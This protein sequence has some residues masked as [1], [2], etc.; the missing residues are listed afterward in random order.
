ML[1]RSKYTQTTLILI[2]S[3]LVCGFLSIYFGKELNWDLAN[4][5]Y[6]N[7]FSFWQERW[8]IDY[9]PTS[10][11]HVHFTPTLD[12]LTYFLIN[13]FSPRITMF[14]MGAIHGMN[15]WLL[16]LIARLCLAEIGEIP[17]QRLIAISL[18]FLGMYGPTVLPG[19]GSFQHD[20]LVSIF[21]L[22]FVLL[23][24]MGLCRYK[25]EKKFAYGLFCMGSVLL[26][27]GAGCKLTAALFVGGALPAF[28]LL[29]LPLWQRIKILSVFS[30]GMGVGILCASGY[31][32][33]FLWQHYH[34]PFF[35]LLN[36]FFHSPDFPAY[37]WKDRRFLPHG[38]LQ[39]LFYP[40]Y[41]AWDGRTNDMPFRDFRYPI[42]YTLFIVYF[43]SAGWKY[44]RGAA[45][46]LAITSQWLF[47]F[48]IF[49]YI[50]WQSYFSIMRYIAAL[51]M[52]APLV[53]YLVLH[54]LLQ[55][56]PPRL[57]VAIGIFFLIM[58]TTIPS[59]MIR[60]EWYDTDYFNIK[61]PAFV[62]QT[63]E[64][65]V[66][67]AFSAYAVHTD[68]RPQTYL[69]PFFPAKWR[70]IGIPF[71]E[72]DY[73]LPSKLTSIIAHD[74]Y[75]Y[76]LS[77]PAYMPKMYTI[78]DAMG[79]VSHGQ[80]GLITSDRQRITNE[81]TWLCVVKKQHSIKK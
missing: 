80:C 57:L 38:W 21:I 52:L 35:P 64:A 56:R 14:I 23:Q 37:N 20:N 5:H 19:I 75:L 43:I 6:Y 62:T 9:W 50:L 7:S 58:G 24:L 48:F 47:L 28:L 53:I 11:V 46:Q 68:P 67:M 45:H 81:E 36:G 76:L 72:M 26:G 44:M 55:Q 25:H 33:L 73:T 40:F 17:Y 41:Y 32:M 42:L 10:Y 77:P 65:H 2:T 51:E 30:I 16:Y 13:H 59:S 79:F 70:F 1:L 22:G 39:T 60:A 78:A 71:S 12:F 66:L 34:N 15:V 63:P 27:L 49:S 69:I 61:L 74:Q 29:S 3:M 8:K 4:Y 54:Q 18:A 31:W